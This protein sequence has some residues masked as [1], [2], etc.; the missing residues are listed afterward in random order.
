L[1]AEISI[2]KII[3]NNRPLVMSTS[4]HFD[5]IFVP[6]VAPVLSN[7]QKNIYVIEEVLDFAVTSIQKKW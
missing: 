1:Q 5:L 2:T 3:K 7:S 6:I 4:F